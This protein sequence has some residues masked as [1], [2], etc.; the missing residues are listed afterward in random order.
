MPNTI[1]YTT[2][3]F[4]HYEK[5]TTGHVLNALC[6]WG[7][8]ISVVEN[9]HFTKD[10][11]L[12]DSRGEL[13]GRY[14]YFDGIEQPLFIFTNRALG[15]QRFVRVEEE[16]ATVLAPDFRLSLS[17]H[18]TPGLIID[19]DDATPELHFKLRRCLTNYMYDPWY[20]IHKAAGA[21]F[22]G[23]AHYP[24]GRFFYIEFWLPAGAQ[25]FVDRLNAE[26]R[27]K[28]ARDDTTR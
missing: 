13:F 4:G 25:A 20:E 18:D 1:D 10:G 5:G 21:F 26:Y 3:L 24:E 6:H 14:K 8:P 28:E 22:Q 23:G 11:L 17:T 19:G 16:G 9:L 15:K 7:V 12:K 2:G 27:P